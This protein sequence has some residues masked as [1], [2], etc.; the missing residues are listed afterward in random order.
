MKMKSPTP[1]NNT[2]L[3]ST[4]IRLRRSRWTVLIALLMTVATIPNW[5]PGSRTQAAVQA[6]Q[7]C[8]TFTGAA[9]IVDPSDH[10]AVFVTTNSEAIMV[11]SG[12]SV[13]LQYSIPQWGGMSKSVQSLGVRYVATNGGRVR[14]NIV[15]RP[16]QTGGRRIISRFD[17]NYATP[18]TAFQFKQTTSAGNFDFANN[19]YSLEVLIDNQSGGNVGLESIQICGAF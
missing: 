19:S 13:R 4:Q 18:A 7:F 17:S 14:V 10:N 1:N 2:P 15:E 12:N 8:Q 3:T 6:S 16:L 5:N 11:R 9:G